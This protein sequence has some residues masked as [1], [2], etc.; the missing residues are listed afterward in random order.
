MTM[1]RSYKTGT[2]AQTIIAVRIHRTGTITPLVRRRGPDGRMQNITG[3]AWQKATDIAA[4]DFVAR[5]QPGHSGLTVAGPSLWRGAY[6]L[7]AI[8]LGTACALAREEL[9]AV[10]LPASETPVASDPFGTHEVWFHL[11]HGRLTW[12]SAAFSGATIIDETYPE[13]TVALRL[14]EGSDGEISFAD[15]VFRTATGER[16]G[17]LAAA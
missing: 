9:A 6:S 8:P 5:V 16:T 11:E 13:I 14:P 10:E 3:P 12:R 17:V 1:N 7:A 2:L 4:A 15:P